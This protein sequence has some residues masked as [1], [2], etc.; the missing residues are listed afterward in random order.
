MTLVAR[1]A[2]RLA[3]AAALLRARS[4]GARATVEGMAANRFL[5][6]PEFSPGLLHLFS[7]LLGPALRAL[8]GHFVRS[9][10]R[11]LPPPR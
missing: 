11:G 9:E 2:E 6:L 3:E 10:R 1:G 4:T 7:G 5:V 8:Q